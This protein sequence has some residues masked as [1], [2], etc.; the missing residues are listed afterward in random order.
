MSDVLDPLKKNKD[1]IL[2][3]EIGAL[4]HDIG[5][6]HPDFVRRQSL[7]GGQKFYHGN[8][9]GF[10]ESELVDKIK[11]KHFEFQING[12]SSSVYKIITEHH[13]PKDKIVEYLQSCDKIDSADDKGI[14]RVKQSVENTLIVS[15]FG[16]P[17]E[18]IDL[19]VLKSRLEVLQSNLITPFEDY[20]CGKLDIKGFRRSLINNLK[21]VFLHT[22]GETRI[23]ANDVTLWD[24]SYSTASLFKSVLAALMLGEN[25][26]VNDLKWRIFGISWNGLGF[27]NKGKKIGDILARR[28]IIEDIKEELKDLCEIK[29]PIGNAI[30]EDINGM[31]FTFP[32]LEN[33]KAAEIA[34]KLSSEA[35]KIITQGSESE[36]WPVFKLS[37]ESRGLIIIAKELDFAE[38]ERKIPRQTPVLY[39]KEESNKE[40]IGNPC[41]SNSQGG[42]KDICPVCRL[43]PKDIDKEMCAICEDRKRDRLAI[44]F[45]DRQ[46]TI[47]LDEVA[48]VNNRIALVS[49]N[50][51][52]D[53]WL[54]GTMINTIYSQTFEDWAKGKENNV[55]VQRILKDNNIL[56]GK[57]LYQNALNIAKWIANN[58]T[59]TETGPLIRYFLEKGDEKNIPDEIKKD[60]NS[61]LRYLFTQ[62][63]SPARLYRIWRETEEFS[64]IVTRDIK[65]RIYY[66]GWRRIRFKVDY[67]E[68]KKK[69]G[70]NI[71]VRAPYVIKIKNLK[72]ESI[73]VFHMSNGEFYTIES[74]EK[75]KFSDKEGELAVRQAL[76]EGFYYLAD[77]KDVDEILLSNENE[78]IKADSNSLQSESYYP[79]I[80]ITKTPL[81][82]R[83]IV[84]AED[85]I[86]IIELVTKLFNERFEKVLGKLPLNIKLLAANRKFPLYVLLDSEKRM[87]EEKE[88]KEAKEM[89]PWWNT[90]GIRNDKYYSF[91]PIK[92]LSEN[93]K[94]TLD[95][96]DRLSKAKSYFLYPGYFDFDFL[97][98]TSDR[99]RI[100]Y[101]RGKRGN[102][103]YKLYT[104]RPYYFYQISEMIELWEVLKNN[105]SNSQINFI[106]EMLIRKLKEWRDIKDK[107]KVFK[108]FAKAT[109]A[110]AFGDKWS[111]LED[112]TK[113]FLVESACNK[114]LLDIICLFKHVIKV[115][116]VR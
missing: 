96:L 91:Y 30:Y 24:H 114:F 62:N 51:G 2:K 71:K 78:V 113:Y 94:Y 90:I 48:D 42:N 45:S 16:Y 98:G 29:Y 68:L 35:L 69:V 108:E 40:Y 26:S 19:Q 59:K 75:F 93:E 46:N 44:W 28:K 31:Y 66:Y 81:S 92:R 74:L 4:L 5:K 86:K 79:F 27:I 72:P 18:K 84:P 64:E 107:D 89:K 22:L 85:S 106:E 76:E 57:N 41:L 102:S 115:R 77:E 103:E 70:K 47:W 37:S 97:V 9:D 39:I 13:N 109:L 38:R 33:N 14:V 7:E 80:E 104:S 87:L 52:L 100:Y 34:K 95:D 116:E 53:K 60:H 10:L 8:I 36:L 6:C 23:P 12:K 54:D 21:P 111:G 61:L 58:V 20:I 11:S 25:L 105:L 49:I 15:P 99:Y 17:K 50:F 67:E 101:E 83:L 112:K 43:R 3:G 65:E 88:F 63:P 56:Q 73:L 55:K 82:L 110:D 32:S 1:S